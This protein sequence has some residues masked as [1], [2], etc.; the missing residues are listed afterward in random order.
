M[1]KLK[2]FIISSIAYILYGC[3]GGSTSNNPSNPGIS[4]A[5]SYQVL[6]ANGKIS[7]IKQ[8]LGGSDGHSGVVAWV[9]YP[10]GQ[11]FARNQAN[12]PKNVIYYYS[13]LAALNAAK[14]TLDSSYYH[15]ANRG[16]ATPRS[17]SSKIA[18]G[19]EVYSGLDLGITASTG[20]S[21]LGSG[22]IYYANQSTAS[23]GIESSVY[24]Q[25]NGTPLCY[26]FTPQ[27]GSSTN[28]SGITGSA[29]FNTTNSDSTF[30]STL[31]L[32]TS[33]SGSYNLFKASDA[34]NY[35]TNYSGNYSTGANNFFSY[36]ALN[37]SFQV[38]GL[39]AMGQAM[40]QNNPQLFMQ[41][42]GTS[43]ITNEAIG[44]DNQFISTITSANNSSSTSIS[45]TLN[46]SYSFANF[47]TALSSLTKNSNSSFNLTSTYTTNGDYMFQES[48]QV[49]NNNGTPVYVS[50]GQTFQEFLSNWNSQSQQITGVTACNSAI[51]QTSTS[52]CTAYLSSLGAII[53]SLT[54]A[55][56]SDISQ[57]GYPH[58]MGLFEQ[59]PDG[60][61]E[62]NQPS[63]SFSAT[64]A[65][66]PVSNLISGSFPDTY[67]P[68]AANL[69]NHIQ[70]IF[71]LTSLAGK[72]SLYINML[73]PNLLEGGGIMNVPAQLGNLADSYSTDYA[74]LSNEVI[75]CMESSV[76]CATMT[77]LTTS[78]P[79]TFYASTTTPY[80]AND[81]MWADKMWNSIILQYSGTYTETGNIDSSIQ[82]TWPQASASISLQ[83]S[84]PMAVFYAS[85]SNISGALQPGIIAI[86]LSQIVVTNPVFGQ[87]AKWQDDD[88]TWGGLASYPIA[89]EFIVDYPVSGANASISAQQTALATFL[90]GYANQTVMTNVLPMGPSKFLGGSLTVDFGPNRTYQLPTSYLNSYFSASTG[91]YSSIYNLPEMSIGVSNGNEAYGYSMFVY[92]PNNGLVASYQ[93]YGT[94]MAAGCYPMNNISPDFGFNFDRCFNMT[95]GITNVLQLSGS[96][97]SFGVNPSNPQTIPFF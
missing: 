29:Q 56:D 78:D 82:N 48:H 34:F 71:N 57:F 2:L 54:G 59:F 50:A 20:N 75:S 91:G 6:A 83:N 63:N 97:P 4:T 15:T 60:V 88:A 90:Q 96:N 5:V 42:C 52:V 21:V 16:A 76:Q 7:V 40:L 11:K 80:I 23:K 53:S 92:T 38:A 39:S 45:N 25:Y 70:L 10:H 35:D 1:K 58:E 14:P 18:S 30:S 33:I 85:S 3:G 68:Y 84:A 55:V 64:L 8:I 86:G 44:V 94:N 13:S 17:N 9:G 62:V 27:V 61:T 49:G 51:T 22:D 93:A 37:T 67:T 24:A 28:T 65:T 36:F 77:Q 74:T 47:S 89:G 43:Y 12:N 31:N 73:T 81:T 19:A 87:T 26:Q 32:K 41:V 69:Q 46:A 95:G 79:Y 72:A 66:Q